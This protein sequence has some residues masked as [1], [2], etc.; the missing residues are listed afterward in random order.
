METDD[1]GMI[2][3]AQDL[4]LAPDATLVALDFL[5]GYDLERDFD[6]VVVAIRSAVS[7]GLGKRGAV[8]GG[9]EACA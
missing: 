9:A 5:L 4:H 7:G 1:V 6:S 8:G 2:E 3:P